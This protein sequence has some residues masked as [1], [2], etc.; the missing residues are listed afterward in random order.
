VVVHVRGFYASDQYAQDRNSL[1]RHPT[2]KHPQI[3]QRGLDD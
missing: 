1:A 3:P 2:G